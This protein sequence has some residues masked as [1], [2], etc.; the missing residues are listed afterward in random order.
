LHV[1]LQ[2][3]VVGG[4][5]ARVGPVALVED[6][7]EGVGLAVEDETVAQQGDRPH[8]GV[9]LDGV[10]GSALAVDELDLGVDEVGR[11]GVPEQLVAVIVDPR[12]RQRDPAAHLRRGDGVRIV[13]Q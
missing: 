8:R 7:S 5:E 13:R 4:G 3:V 12:V 10:E 1:E 6:E 11:V 9:T 2:R